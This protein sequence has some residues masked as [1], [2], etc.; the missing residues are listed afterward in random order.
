M[1]RDSEG[2]SL[3]WYTQYI[4]NIIKLSKK[5]YMATSRLVDPHTHTHSEH[6]HKMYI[7]YL[8]MAW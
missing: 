3:L 2:H 8:H 4:L 6:V 7:I 5:K 1:K